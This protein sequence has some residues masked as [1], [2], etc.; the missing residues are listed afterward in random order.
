MSLELRNTGII[1]TTIIITIVSLVLFFA[2]NR[3]TWVYRYNNNFL[4]M[5]GIESSHVPWVRY[6]VSWILGTC[7][8][9]VLLTLVINMGFTVYLLSGLSGIPLD[10]VVI[11]LA[12]GA[13]I[14]AIILLIA[15]IPPVLAMPLA[16]PTA[17]GVFIF[18]TQFGYEYVPGLPSTIVYTLSYLSTLLYL[19]TVA[20]G[21]VAIFLS[22]YLLL[23]T[24]IITP[25]LERRR[26]PSNE[27][28]VNTQ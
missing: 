22:F 7:I 28:V 10:P 14:L 5:F 20:I 9:T 17:I 15:A 16:C 2:R 25:L 6:L 23:R 3:I 13:I 4:G 1:I 19:G 12:I 27:E 21:F 8:S 26:G 11:S 18:L 24:Y